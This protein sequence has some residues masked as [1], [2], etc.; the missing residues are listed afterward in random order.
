MAG[1]NVPLISVSAVLRRFTRGGANLGG[2]RVRGAKP[3]DGVVTPRV[4]TLPDRGIRER[5]RHS[6]H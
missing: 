5:V 2:P 1:V 3:G 6:P 4:P